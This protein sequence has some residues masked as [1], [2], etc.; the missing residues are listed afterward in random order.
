M[1]REHCLHASPSSLSSLAVAA[2]VVFCATTA[3]AKDKRACL[4]AYVAYKS[5]QEREASGHLR[6]AR[7]LLQTCSE[8]A[9]AACSGLAQKC[10]ARYGQIGSEMPSVVPV[11]TDD[12]GGPVVDVQV[13]IDG[14]PLTSKLDG[15]GLPVDIGLHEF[16]FATEGGVFATQRVLVVEGQRNR[17][18]TVQMRGADAT[19]K[20]G[21]PA[22]KADS[23]GAARPASDAL[24][25]E[26]APSDKA[27][28]Q[29]SSADKPDADKESSAGEDATRN[30]SP[31][32]AKRAPSPFAY[33]MGGTGVAAVGAGVLLTLWGR[34][35]N[36]ALAACTPNCRQSSVDHVR[37][38]YI[39]SDVALGAG[40][41]SL[42]VA[43][44][45][46]L[47]RPS[48]AT[49]QAPPPRAGAAFDVQ[50]TRDGAMASVRGTF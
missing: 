4:P 14:E 5:A 40:V 11:V 16:S 22:E 24:V 12:S 21:A 29:K 15:K 18:L 23:A 36:D 42:G 1:S 25:A 10:T 39:A 41:A 19:A 44:W 8:A 34:K 17:P 45:L 50:P 6:E 20:A 33:V 27:V 31:Q 26:K 48:T 2:V 3:A 43:T 32:P 35:D 37:T 28:S 9:Q 30:A 49:D 38:L 47:H 7:A 13:K 46:F